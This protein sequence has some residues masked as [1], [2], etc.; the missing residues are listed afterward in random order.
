MPVSTNSVT[1]VEDVTF[2]V[3]IADLTTVCARDTYEV[4][5]DGVLKPQLLRAY[6]ELLH[7]I[8]GALRDHLLGREGYSIQD[9]IEL[10]RAFGVRND[11]VGEINWILKKAGERLPS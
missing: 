5:T 9:I 3:R 1:H 10:M 4:G 11:R 8:I 7:R 6:N 2:L